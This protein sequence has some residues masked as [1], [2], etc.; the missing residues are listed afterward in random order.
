MAEE[1]TPSSTADK[2]FLPMINIST[3]SKPGLMFFEHWSILVILDFFLSLISQITHILYKRLFSMYANDTVKDRGS[4]DKI[5]ALYAY[6][7]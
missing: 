1:D 7:R 5:V 3:R 2:D 6:L 4:E